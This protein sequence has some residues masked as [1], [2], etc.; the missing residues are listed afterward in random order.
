[1]KKYYLFLFVIFVPM[2]LS[3]QN[4]PELGAQVWLEPSDS[5]E[6]IDLWFKTMADHNLKVGGLFIMWNYVEPTPGNWDFSLYDKAFNVADKYK[7]GIV[8]TF[9]TNRRAAHRCDYYQL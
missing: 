3:T 4:L 6:E 5:D 9:E 8:A 2:L 1:M 7:V